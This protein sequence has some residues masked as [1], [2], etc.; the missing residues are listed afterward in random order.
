MDRGI[1]VNCTWYQ[2]FFAWK[3]GADK[4][5]NIYLFLQSE[6]ECD[7]YYPVVDYSVDGS[8]CHCN[9]YRGKTPGGRNCSCRIIDIIIVHRN[10]SLVEANEKKGFI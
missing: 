5:R 9:E 8:I 2:S 3:N 10:D 6:S 4:G 1:C 7:L